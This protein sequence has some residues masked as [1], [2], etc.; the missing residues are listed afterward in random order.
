MTYFIGIDP[1][2]S[3]AFAIVADE[4]GMPELWLV[5]DLPVVTE[6]GR[7]RIA[8]AI[9]TAMFKDT[10]NNYGPPALVGIEMVAARPKQGVASAFRF[11][12]SVGVIEGVATALGFPV[13]TITPQSWK[14]T[15][16]LN[17]KD[18]DQAR[19]TV[20]NLWPKHAQWFKRKK[21]IDRAEAALIGLHTMRHG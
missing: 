16:T 8:G 5:E 15:F 3:G 9:L 6:H 20:L 11:G 1:G 10:V 4:C 13:R 17:G 12:Q 21:D 18:K 2:V 7:N 14:K 19:S